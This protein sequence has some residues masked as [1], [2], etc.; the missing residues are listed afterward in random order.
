MAAQLFEISTNL[1]ILGP[2]MAI[3]GALRATLVM[4]AASY[5]LLLTVLVVFGYRWEQDPMLTKDY[6]VFFVAEPYAKEGNVEKA[7]ETLETIHNLDKQ[8]PF[9]IFWSMGS[10]YNVE[11]GYFANG[12]ERVAN[13]FYRQGKL[14]VAEKIVK[15]ALK[16]RL[17]YDDDDKLGGWHRED[18]EELLEKIQRAQRKRD[19][20]HAADR[21]TSETQKTL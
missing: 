19:P 16:M 5:V 18:L 11:T 12:D 20:T 14:D 4:N 9:R 17:F 13:I 8:E 6:Y 10:Q 21:T 1:K 15:D 3:N 2:G 7:L